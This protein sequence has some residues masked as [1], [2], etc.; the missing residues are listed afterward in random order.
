MG[1]SDDGRWGS[2]LCTADEPHAKRQTAAP[3]LE[4]AAARVSARTATPQHEGSRRG[5]CLCV[6]P[7][8]R[9]CHQSLR[10]PRAGVLSASATPPRPQGQAG[11]QMWVR[12]A[13]FQ[14]KSAATAEPIG[15]YEEHGMPR[16]RAS[17]GNAGCYLLEEMGADAGI[18]GVH[19]LG[20]GRQMQ[21]PM[22]RAAQPKEVAAFFRAFTGPPELRTYSSAGVAQKAPSP[23]DG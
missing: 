23:F 2:E 14:L 10:V 3:R 16:V 18:R 19:V 17:P 7:Q 15:V 1:A 4:S 12:I 6:G 5:T 20:N 13:G 11:C 8:G 9:D 22:S 21:Q